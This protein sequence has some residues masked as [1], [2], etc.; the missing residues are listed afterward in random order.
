MKKRVVVAIFMVI[1]LSTFT[2]MAFAAN[3][4]KLSVNGQEINTDV[5]P[6][7]INGRIMAPIRWVAQALGADV[8]WDG[9]TVH[10]TGLT[11]MPDRSISKQQ[12]AQWIK[13]QGKDKADSYF[14]EGLSYD[15]VN[16]DDDDDLEIMAKIDGGVHLGQFFIFDKDSAGK[17]QLIAEQDWKV[18]N[19]DADNP[20]D[21]A[22]KKI[23]KLVTRTGGTGLDI[24]NVHLWYM[25][26]G[27][28]IEAWQGT[29]LERSVMAVL[30]PESYYKKAGGYQV[31]VEGKRLYAWETR[32]QL[33]ED[34]VTPIGEIITATTLYRF[35]G[36]GF[37]K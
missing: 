32:H 22:G 35:N 26:Q 29:L 9:Y 27:K 6:Q 31:D 14:I 4:V 25:E 1:V 8:Q 33:A 30:I 34:G 24:F 36:T 7:L 17:Y 5:P 20:I 23:F 18:E 28:Y 10:I 19:W 13:S 3:P 15:L 37:I 16:L 21:I 2:V 12:V 11:S